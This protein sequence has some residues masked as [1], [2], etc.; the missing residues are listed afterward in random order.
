MT[1]TYDILLGGK[2]VGQ[3]TVT[4]Q[5]LYYRFVCRCRITGEVMYKLTVTC[6]GQTE[7]LGLLVPEG[8]DYVLSTRLPAKRFA[9]GKPEFRAVPR[10]S[11]MTGKFIPVYPDEPFAY[12]SRLHSAF[13]ENRGGQLGVVLSEETEDSS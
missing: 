8:K 1:G 12:I 6:G 3:A 10:H 2:P 4:E 5:G 9:Q 11:R 7:N 13:L